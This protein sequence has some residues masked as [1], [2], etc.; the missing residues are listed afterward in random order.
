MPEQK[1]ETCAYHIVRYQPNLIRDEWVNIGVLL[2]DP[3]SGRVRQRWLEEPADFARLRRMHPAADPE[4]LSRLP[5][6]FERQLAVPRAATPTDA[7]AAQATPAD[8][9]KLLEKFEQTLSNAVQLSPRK[10]VLT[11]DVEG[12]LE[13]VFREQVEPLRE[14]RRGAR[15]VETRSELR[16]RAADYFRTEKILRWMHRGV[17]VAEFTYP[18]D[19]MRMDFAYRRNGTRGFVQSLPLAR[20]PSQAKLLAFTADA[21]RERVEHA[22]FLAV[23]EREPSGNAR[24][25]FVAGVLADHGVRVMPLPQLRKWAHEVAGVLHANG[26]N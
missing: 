14:G 19:P 26:E 16:S 8:A 13:R 2:L 22:E 4:V 1:L 17:R 3:A 11:A 15:G 7:A 6:E 20:D 25:Q 5:G 12:E 24:D 18:G 9:V 10:G 21:I 23:T